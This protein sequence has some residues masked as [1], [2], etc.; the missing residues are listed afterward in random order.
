MRSDRQNG[1]CFTFHFSPFHFSLFTFPVIAEEEERLV[2]ISK[3]IFNCHA[4][5]GPADSLYLR[6]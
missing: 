1:S 3:H 5:A 6:Y 4:T 2:I